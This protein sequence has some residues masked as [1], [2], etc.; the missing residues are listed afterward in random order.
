M[1]R[2]TPSLSSFVPESGIY[3]PGSAR[4]PCRRLAPPITPPIPNPARLCSSPVSENHATRARPAGIFGAS[5]GESRRNMEPHVNYKMTAARL[6]ISNQ[7]CI[8]SLQLGSFVPGGVDPIFP[9]QKSMRL[10]VTGMPNSNSKLINFPA[11]LPTP[12]AEDQAL[13]ISFLPSPSNPMFKTI[14]NTMLSSAMMKPNSSII[15]I[16]QNMH[17]KPLKR[18]KNACMRADRHL[19][20]PVLIGPFVHPVSALLVDPFLNAFCDTM[21][22]NTKDEEPICISRS[23]KNSRK[24]ARDGVILQV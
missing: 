9:K 21:A 17:H 5:A 20:S 1:P 6:E 16:R 12:R 10:F 18:P 3:W 11:D 4:T 19:L 15:S 14:I 8:Y 13:R 2:Q 7:Q 23:V 24:I 22:E